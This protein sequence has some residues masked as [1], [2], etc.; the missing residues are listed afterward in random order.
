MPLNSLVRLLTESMAITELIGE[1]APETEKIAHNKGENKPAPKAQIIFNVESVG[2]STLQP[3]NQSTDRPTHATARAITDREFETGL[4][5]TY[6]SLYVYLLSS[7]PRSL[8]LD[9]PFEPILATLVDLVELTIDHSS[10]CIDLGRHFCCDW[11]TSLDSRH[12]RC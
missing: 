12:R 2:K 8:P 3:T 9:F 5:R 10:S 4:T 6:R 1:Q 11:C 7:H